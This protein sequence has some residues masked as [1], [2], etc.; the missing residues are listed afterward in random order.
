M[1]DTPETDA[2]M[3]GG[4]YSFDADFARNLERQRNMLLDA[5]EM[6]LDGGLEGPSK[7]AIDTALEAIAS[8]K[9]ESPYVG[10]ES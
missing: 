5:L 4:S 8:V 9:L 6:M 7:Q 3:L 2:H 1:S 10:K